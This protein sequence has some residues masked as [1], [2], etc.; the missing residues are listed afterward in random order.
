MASWVMLKVSWCVANN[1]SV[2]SEA[3]IAKV[4]MGY[5]LLLASYVGSSGSS[6]KT[7]G[8]ELCYIATLCWS[9]IV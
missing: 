8:K 6:G 3:G 9:S 1:I 5:Q 7:T 4:L 2:C